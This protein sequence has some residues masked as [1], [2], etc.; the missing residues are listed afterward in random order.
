[1]WTSSNESSRGR[2]RRV[3]GN[4]AICREDS[5]LPVL[6]G[7]ADDQLRSPETLRSLALGHHRRTKTGKVART[8][9]QPSGWDSAMLCCEEGLGQH[10]GVE[11][12]D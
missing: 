1:M 9:A 2:P 5:P 10:D 8:S 12:I 3:G 7:E 11:P 6:Q 4:L